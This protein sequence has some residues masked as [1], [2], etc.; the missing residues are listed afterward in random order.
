LKLQRSQLRQGNGRF[1]KL[2]SAIGEIAYGSNCVDC[3]KRAGSFVR[4]IFIAATFAVSANAGPPLL[5]DDPDTPGPNHWEINLAITTEKVGNEWGFETPLLDLNY[6][7]GERIQLKYEVP[8]IL[9]DR[10]DQG[11][12]AGPANSKVGVKWRFLDQEKAWLDVSTYPQF[13]F[14][15]G[16]TSVN[17]GLAEDGWAVLLPIELAH[18]FGALTI[19][20]E[21][22]Y[23]LN[24]RRPNEWI[25]GIA[26][27]YE[28]SERLSIMGEL[29]GTADYRLRDDELVSNLGLRWKWNKQ[30]SILTSAGRSIGASGEGGTGFSSYFALQ[31]TL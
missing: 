5:T 9:V 7:V 24:Q 2:D 4:L 30:I 27:E 26:A 1:I 23:S 12:R 17:R 25:C 10:E 14:N 21:V 20:S 19:Y 6:G 13:E 28:I 22:G 8:F 18:K 29:Y 31:V 16:S 3:F 15:H 11:V